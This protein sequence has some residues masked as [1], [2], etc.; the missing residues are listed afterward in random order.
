MIGL[1]FFPLKSADFSGA[2]TSDE[3]LRTSA[4]EATG[5]L[6]LHSGFQSPGFRIPDS[7]SKNL[8]DSGTPILLLGAITSA[9]SS[10]FFQMIMIFDFFGDMRIFH[11]LSVFSFS[12]RLNVGSKWLGF[13]V[14]SQESYKGNI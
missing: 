9:V 3:P 1:R 12:F 5:F 10:D 2:G 4:W 8:T 11:L 6:E 13:S 14:R 7:T